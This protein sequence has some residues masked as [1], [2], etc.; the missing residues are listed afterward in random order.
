VYSRDTTRDIV[1]I[2]NFNIKRRYEIRWDDT[3]GATYAK[4]GLYFLWYSNAVANSPT[5]Q[6]EWTIR[7]SDC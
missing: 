3:A 7:Y 5:V 4:N 2:R 6:G 1:A